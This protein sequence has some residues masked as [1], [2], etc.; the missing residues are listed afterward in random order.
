M[1]FDPHNP[2]DIPKAKEYLDGLIQ[3]GDPFE[4]KRKAPK[5]T[6]RQNAYLHVILGFFASEYGCSLEEAKLLYFK[7]ECN[8]EIFERMG[9]N[10][11]GKEVTYY[12]STKDLDTREMSLATERF[13]NWSASV[14][15][16][17]LPS[18]NEEQFLSYCEKVIEEN[19]E[20]L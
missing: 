8:R 14:A 11:K 3:K 10:R 15:D 17:Y 12:R 18:P 6:N 19:K 5:R 9:V 2:F 1:I 13:R 16:I 7:K 4:M 20:F